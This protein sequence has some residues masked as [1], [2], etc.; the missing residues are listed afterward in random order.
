LA[1]A[2]QWSNA[3]ENFAEMIRKEPAENCGTI[4][5][6]SSKLVYIFLAVECAN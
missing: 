4:V 5:S 1:L 3:I 6:L 2:R